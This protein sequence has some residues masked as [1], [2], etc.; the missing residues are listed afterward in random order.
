[1]AV[2]IV[3]QDVIDIADA[4]ATELAA[5]TLDQ[6]TA[7]LDQVCVH[8]PEVYGDLT[9]VLQ[10]Y[11]AAHLANQVFTLAAGEGAET[12]ENIGSVSASRNQPVNNPQANEG[13][14]ETTYGRTYQYYLDEFK[15]RHVVA[16]GLYSG[17]K[18][19]G[20]PVIIPTC[21]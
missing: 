21:S 11:W 18:V 14:L 4:I 13:H 9:P 12:T 19:S 3:W 20:F 7:I 6:Q 2:V 1:M 16:F 15:K 17:G 5:F 10:K 8:V